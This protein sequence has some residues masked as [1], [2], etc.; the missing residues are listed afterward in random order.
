MYDTRLFKQKDKPESKLFTTDINES[1]VF[2]IQNDAPE[3]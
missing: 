1:K 3:P 2:V